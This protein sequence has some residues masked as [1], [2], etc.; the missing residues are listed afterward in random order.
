[1]SR[2]EIL[3]NFFRNEIFDLDDD[4]VLY[5]LRVFSENE[6]FYSLKNNLKIDSSLECSIFEISWKLGRILGS[7]GQIGIDNYII[8]EIMISTDNFKLSYFNFLAGYWDEVNPDFNIFIDFL[9]FIVENLADELWSN[10]LS[11]LSIEPIAIVYV[12]NKEKLN[13]NP[14]ILDKIRVLKNYVDRFE[15]DSPAKSLLSRM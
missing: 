3:N 8:Q 1:M 9:G 4:E 6:I 14:Y 10:E 12:K 15:L 2:N 7:C 13:I 11:I 5:F